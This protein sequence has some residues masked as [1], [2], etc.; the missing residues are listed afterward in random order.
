MIS[1]T[2]GFLLVFGVVVH[3]IAHF[4]YLKNQIQETC[5]ADDEHRFKKFQAVIIH[6]SKVLE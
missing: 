2:G 1:L 4:V 6:H 5:N 3:L